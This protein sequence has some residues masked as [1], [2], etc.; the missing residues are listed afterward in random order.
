VRMA[1]L[2]P[3]AEEVGALALVDHHV[4]PVLGREVTS[5]EFERLITESDRPVPAG[6]SQFDSQLG[7]A[8]RRWCG[9]VLGLEPS[10]PA[11][12]YLARRADLGPAETARLL[13]AASG[14]DR[15]LVDTGYPRDG[16]LTLDGMRQLTGGRADE[17]VRLEQVAEGLAHSGQVSAATFAESFRAALWQ[18][19]ERARG[20]KS[21]VAYRHGFAFDPSPPAP[22]EV[23]TAAGQWLRAIETTGD[24][25]LRHV[26]LLRYLLWTGVERGLPVQLHTGFGD[27]DVDLRLA[28]PLLLRGFLERTGPR[29]V[30]VMLLHCYPYHREA[31]YLAQAYPHVHFDLGLAINYLGARATA[32]VAESLELAPFAK[33]LYSSDAFA[34]PEL[35]YL[36]ALLWRRATARVLGEWVTSGEWSHADAVR[37][38]GLIGSGNAMRVYKLS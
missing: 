27:P 38:A 33:V 35:V 2:G 16:L 20:V 26:V 10:A 37:T 28:N 34:L 23:T 30:P 11:G 25:R 24:A 22:A 8:V 14:V 32:V 36:G 1:D 6:T 18:R 9:P 13:I 7:V 19:T 31:G 15:L 12:E 5:G 3:I 21:I 4:H 29:G 17:I